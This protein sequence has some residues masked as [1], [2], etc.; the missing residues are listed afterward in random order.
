LDTLSLVVIFVV[1]FLVVKTITSSKKK[2]QPRRKPSAL[3]RQYSGNETIAQGNNVWGQTTSVSSS[4][5]GQFTNATIQSEDR[6]DSYYK[7]GQYQRAFEEYNRE[8]KTFKA[9]L[10]LARQGP[11]H[12][13][14]VV[15]YLRS[16]NPD[17]LNVTVSNL[18]EQLYNKFG[19][20]STSA[21]LYRAIGRSDEAMAIEIANSIPSTTKFISQIPSE[22]DYK[23]ATYVQNEPQIREVKLQVSTP[24]PQAETQVVEEAH[25]ISG[26]EHTTTSLPKIASATLD[27]PCVVCKKQ[28]SAGDTYVNCPHCGSPGHKRHVLEWAKAIDKC[29]NCKERLSMSDFSSE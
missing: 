27:V 17:V 15:S 9:A 22:E 23:E 3:S 4:R 19:E 5:Q 13:S 26:I 29:K 2:N 6:G 14:E 12:T 10:S 18:V 11:D 25:I 8:S 20:A 28:I 16:K 7:S 1:I 21:A 24:P